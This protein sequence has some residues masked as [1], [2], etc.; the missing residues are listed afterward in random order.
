LGTIPSAIVL[1]AQPDAD[2]RVIRRG[3]SVEFKGIP[4]AFLILDGQHRVFGFSLAKTKLRV[5]VVVYNA[6]TRMEEARL[7]IDINTKQ[8]PVSNELLLDI[9]KLAEYESTSEKLFGEVFDSFNTDPNSPLLGLMSATERASGKISRV[10]FN[11]ALKQILPSFEGAPSDDVYE[12]LRNYFAACVQGLQ[13]LNAESAI[14]NA[15]VFRAFAL[16]F[17]D[18]AQRV[19]DRFNSRFTPENFSTVLQ[20]VFAKSK[21]S[22]FTK[23]IRS[24]RNLC[25]SLSH[26]LRQQFSLGKKGTS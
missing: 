12:A 25:E 23:P 17:P 15:V 14:T 7:F 18:V 13:S 10:T 5:P 24:H 22:V 6:L 26:L 16:L 8:R 20:P 2:F 4:K 11:A 21:H 9:K 19:S 3:G 1:S